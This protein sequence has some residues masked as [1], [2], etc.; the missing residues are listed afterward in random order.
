MKPE[1]DQQQVRMQCM[2]VWGGNQP[3]E[4]AISTTGLNLW[5][6]SRPVGNAEAGGDVC[7]LSSCASG[8]ITRLLLADVSGHGEKVSRIA[9]S[10][11]DMMRRS[12]NFV[13]HNR[14]TERMNE[15]FT[16]GDEQGFATAVVA[17]YFAP[18]NSLSVSNAGHPAPLLLRNGQSHWELLDRDQETSKKK[19]DLP[20]GVIESTQYGERKLKAKPGDLLLLYTDAISESRNENGEVLGLEGLRNI[21]NE[22]DANRPETLI[23]QLTDRLTKLHPDNLLD[24][25]VTVVVVQV[26]GTQIPLSNNLTAFW[27]MIK[28]L[29]SGG[30]GWRP[31]SAT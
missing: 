5:L 3:V 15:E 16:K 25:D 1:L 2:E 27:H 21:V 22:L 7:Y 17:S 28:G 6:Y 11:R 4:R 23:A 14:M 20:L 9:L 24:D 10:L 31:L 29:F 8:R 18:L 30:A 13:N 12:I 19:A 26:T